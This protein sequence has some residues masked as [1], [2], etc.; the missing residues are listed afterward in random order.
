MVNKG[1][2]LHLCAVELKGGAFSKARWSQDSTATL[3]TVVNLS[4]REEGHLLLYIQVANGCHTN[5]RPPLDCHWAHKQG[6]CWMPECQP[7]CEMILL[8]S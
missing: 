6:K 4:S 2:S 7:W 8:S 1:R 3:Y 5:Q